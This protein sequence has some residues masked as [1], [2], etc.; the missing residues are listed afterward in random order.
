MTTSYSD[1][2]LLIIGVGLLFYYIFFM[3]KKDIDFKTHSYVLEPNQPNKD[4]SKCDSDS[5]SKSKSKASTETDT[6]D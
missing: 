3:I 2:F 5:E 6:K 1:I 4:D